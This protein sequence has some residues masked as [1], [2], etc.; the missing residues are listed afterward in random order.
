MF[1]WLLLTLV[2]LLV[3][4]FT[5]AVYQAILERRRRETA[6]ELSALEPIADPA[7]GMILGGLTPVLAEHSP[8]M[9][10]KRPTIQQELRQA[11]FYHRS[12]LLEYQAIRAVLVILPLLG[13]G[14]LALLAVRDDIP[15]IAIC[16]V[17]LAGLGF[18]LPR[19]YVNY[20]GRRR[21]R[22]IERG[23]PVAVDLLNLGMSGGQ[24]V[25]AA[26]ASVAREV[27]HSF[28]M[29]ADE[30]QIVHDQAGLARLNLALQHFAD[31]T[32]HADVRHLAMVLTQTE[33][34][35]TDV[36]TG[37]LE[38]ANNLRTNMRH[39]AEAQANRASFWM[40]FPT[41][42]CLWLPATVVLFAPVYHEFGHR[43]AEF[44]DA[45]G[46][47]KNI[48]ES[49]DRPAATVLPNFK[50]DLMKKGA[51]NSAK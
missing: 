45:L 5:F 1:E 11:G 40:L 37:L 16:G 25:H 36:S 31:R 9:A 14:I 38:Y 34:L 10:D 15:R 20:L 13:A 48:I 2:F 49:V 8:I 7:S 44:R 51:P 3:V 46:Q 33:R 22:E 18:S 26:L 42:I 43:R 28:P 24:N 19:L 12:A 6:R 50:M 4:L 47:G 29:L 39:R 23:L 32:G 41:I 27:R 17:M 30:L 21:A 35:G